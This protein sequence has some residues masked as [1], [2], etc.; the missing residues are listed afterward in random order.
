MN[1]F[2]DGGLEIFR[3]WFW[4]CSDVGSVDGGRVG[5]KDLGVNWE[6]VLIFEG[7]CIR[8]LGNL[9]FDK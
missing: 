9:L 6:R 1:W 3:W 7:Y 5:G 4:F 2:L 8:W